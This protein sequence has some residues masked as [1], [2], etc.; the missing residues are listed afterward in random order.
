M[1]VG[2]AFCL[3]PETDLADPQAEG[4]PLYSV[5]ILSTR[6]SFPS[7][8]LPREVHALISVP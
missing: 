1:L 5:I 3:F 8:G 7:I 6:K 4:F 2:A